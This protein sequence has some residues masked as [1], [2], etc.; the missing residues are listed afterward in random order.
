MCIFITFLSRILNFHQ[1]Q[2][3]PLIIKKNINIAKDLKMLD[4]DKNIS[5]SLSKK[6]VYISNHQKSTKIEYHEKNFFFCSSLG[7][8]RHQFTIENN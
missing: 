5:F 3:Y 2:L 8:S 4:I 7:I 1:S 6:K